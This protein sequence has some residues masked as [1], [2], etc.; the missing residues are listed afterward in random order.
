M[1]PDSATAGTAPV[2]ADM[3]GTA[4]ASQVPQKRFRGVTK[5]RRSG[6]SVSLG[7]ALVAL[8]ACNHASVN[9]FMAHLFLNTQQPHTLKLEL[10]THGNRTW[11]WRSALLLCALQSLSN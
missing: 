1:G 7:V 2:Q 10:V 8:T 4:V 5:H 6:R 11:E 9:I 3:D